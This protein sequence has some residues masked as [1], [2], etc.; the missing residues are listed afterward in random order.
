MRSTSVAA[1]LLVLYEL[2]FPIY[3]SLFLHPNN[4]GSLVGFAILTLTFFYYLAFIVLLGAEVNSTAIGL[5]PTTQPLSGLMQ[6]LQ[7]RDELIEPP[8][9]TAGQAP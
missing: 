8:K 6:E 5:R 4:Y 9:E 2:V 7:A 3:V 1:T